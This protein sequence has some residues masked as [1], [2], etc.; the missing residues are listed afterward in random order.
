MALQ[1]INPASGELLESYVEQTVEQVKASVEKASRAFG[2]WRQTGFAERARLLLAAADLLGRQKS[3]LAA[4]MSGEM[5]KPILQAQAEIEKC[6]LVC[7]YYAEN[8]SAMLAPENM[9]VDAHGAYVRFDPLGV[10][11][12]VMPWNFPFWQVFR[13]AAPALMAGNVCLLKHA[14]NVQGCAAAI[15]E[16]FSRAGFPEQAFTTPAHQFGSGRGAGRPS[17]AAGRDLD[18]Q[19]AGRQ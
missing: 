4:L 12:A 8:A 7:K 19:R 6:A 16:I 17:F 2:L 11:L 10:V 3:A 1:S 5:G 14:A 13:F 18:R 15:E 9:V